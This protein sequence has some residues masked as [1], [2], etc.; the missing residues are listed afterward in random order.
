[1]TNSFPGECQNYCLET[2]APPHIFSGVLLNQIQGITLTCTL[3]I[4]D[5]GDVAAGQVGG[6]NVNSFCD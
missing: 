2:P 3:Y 1:V 6:E 4:A 5:R